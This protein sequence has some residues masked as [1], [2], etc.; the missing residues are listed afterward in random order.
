[1]R[2]ADGEQATLAAT[3]RASV[4]SVTARRG[5]RR[6]LDALVPVTLIPLVPQEFYV[7]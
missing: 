3:T 6:T 5:T 7:P 4:T 2:G 1:M